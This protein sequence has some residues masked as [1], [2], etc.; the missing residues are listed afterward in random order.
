MDKVLSEL[1]NLKQVKYN[2]LRDNTGKEPRNN[3]DKYL[4]L[5]EQ[6]YSIKTDLEPLY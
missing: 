6:I 5:Q 2:Y 4:E 1:E 3:L